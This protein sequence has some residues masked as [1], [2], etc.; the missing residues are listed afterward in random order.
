MKLKE[1]IWYAFAAGVVNGVW[2]GALVTVY[3]NIMRK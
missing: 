2:I 3:H 1:L